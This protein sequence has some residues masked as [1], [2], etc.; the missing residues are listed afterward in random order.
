VALEVRA[1]SETETLAIKTELQIVNALTTYSLANTFHGVPKRT[2]PAEG[3]DKTYNAVLATYKAMHRRTFELA[4]EEGLTQPQFYA[5]RVIAKNGAI[6]MKRI[7]DEM[8]VTPANVTGI[9]D[10]LEQKGLIRRMAREG[11]RR[12]TIIELT[13]K[14]IAVQERVASTYSK[15]VHRALGA[16]TTDE[17]ETLRYLLEKLQLEMFR[18]T[19]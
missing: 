10:R 1:S 14:G 9:V 13:P 8:R 18:S 3:N 17:R 11:D 6:P 16:L 19:G 2:E 15:F 7:S 12:A 5:L 4:S